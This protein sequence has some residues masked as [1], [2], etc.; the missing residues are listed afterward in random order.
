MSKASVGLLALGITY[1]LQLTSQLNFMVRQIAD[2]E[3]QMNG[4][5]R[6]VE[7]TENIDQEPDLSYDNEPKK[8]LHRGMQ[9]L[10]KDTNDIAIVRSFD[11]DKVELDVPSLDETI[12]VAPFEPPFTRS[13]TD[14][15]PPGW[16]EKAELVFKNVHMRYRQK[17]PLVLRGLG[18]DK[19]LVMGD[20]EKIGIV[21]RTGAGKSTLMLVLYRLVE[22]AK[23]SITLGGRDIRTLKLNDL[24]NSI[25]MIPQDPVL[26]QGTVRSNLD[27]FNEH[28]DE[29][30]WKR[31]EQASMKKRIEE[32]DGGLNGAITE[33]G[34]NF[35][36]VRGS[37]CAL[38]VLC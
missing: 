17:L 16:P 37:S 24:R 12:S 32:H 33:G 25:V 1:S 11:K 31:L 7:Y 9:L 26:F 28:S 34:A 29:I 8:P 27:P 21:G 6:I 38:R 22:L 10:H 30:I 13:S 5:E 18:G 3:A 2:L 19:G 20:K 23:G 15:P 14:P 36:V 35:S 4:V